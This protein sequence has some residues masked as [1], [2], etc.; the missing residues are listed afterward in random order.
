M[1]LEQWLGLGALLVLVA[2]VVFAFRQ[3]Q[4]VKPDHREDRA[5]GVGSG[6]GG[7]S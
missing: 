3:G 2:F 4:R 6:D 7:G 1:T 5:P